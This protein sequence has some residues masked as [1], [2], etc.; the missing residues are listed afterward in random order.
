MIV[1]ADD[2]VADAHR[3]TDSPG[4]LDLG[5]TDFDRVAVADIFLDRGREPRRRHIEIDRTG[6]E[7]PP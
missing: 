2:D 1:V 3:D 5:A 6:A 4:P 7:P